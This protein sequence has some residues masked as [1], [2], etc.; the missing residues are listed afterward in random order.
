[1]SK[2]VQITEKIPPKIRHNLVKTKAK[3]RKESH[4]HSIFLTENVSLTASQTVI[5]VFTLEG[6]VYL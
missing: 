2:D 5:N 1:M 4:I 6:N 3:S